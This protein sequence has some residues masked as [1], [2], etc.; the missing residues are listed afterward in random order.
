MISILGL[1]DSQMFDWIRNHKYPE[2]RSKQIMDWVT[3]KH[4][5]SFDKM[6]DLPKTLR[7]ELLDSFTISSLR[8]EQ[9]LESI[10]GS[11]KFLWRTDDGICVESVLIRHSEHS[12]LCISSQAGCALGC[13]FCATATMG[14]LRN[15]TTS[16]ILSQILEMIHIL[17]NA[18]R[19]NLVFMGMGEPLLNLENV[20]NSIRFMTSE[21]K[22]NWASQRIT[23]S[24]SGIVPEIRR[25]SQIAPGVKLA[26]SLNAADDKT[27]NQLMPINRVYPL[28]S[29]MHALCEYPLQ[30]QQHHITIEYIMIKGVNDSIEDA[31][32]LG[33]LLSRSRF[34]INLIPFNNASHC[35]YQPSD[36]ETIQKFQR[37]LSDGDFIVRIR[38]SAGRDIA[39]ACGQ[40]AATTKVK[41]DADGTK[42]TH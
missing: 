15:L 32:K 21:G 17:G 13:K 2:Y 40:L 1:D 14:I 10:D 16:E 30:S 3:Q 22:M 23:V 9:L 39:A 18:D 38:R 31:R 7:K 20:G 35:R 37:I 28:R 34:K 19:V 11:Q 5:L 24:T 29:L 26:V 12:T 8:Q 33:K 6:S 4:C 27:R 41:V 36:D 25:F 42:S